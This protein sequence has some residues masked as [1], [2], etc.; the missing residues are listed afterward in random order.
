LIVND[1]DLLASNRCIWLCSFRLLAR[2]LVLLIDTFTTKFTGRWSAAI[3]GVKIR[4]RPIRTIGAKMPKIGIVFLAVESLRFHW[5]PDSQTPFRNSG[6]SCPEVSRIR[7][8]TWPSVK[9]G[10]ACNNQATLEQGS[11]MLSS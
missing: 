6:N 7:P 2:S 5:P 1:Q 10:S 3:G 11:V 4:N 9:G 8:F